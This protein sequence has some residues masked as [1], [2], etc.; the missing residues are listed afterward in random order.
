MITNRCHLT[1]IKKIS[2]TRNFFLTNIIFVENEI[3]KSMNQELKYLIALNMLPKIG[4]ITARKL[5]AYTGSPGAVFKEK[6]AHLEKIPGI[7][8][9]LANQIIKNDTLKKAE[10]EIN[11]IQKY[12]I[13][14]LAYLD[15][16]YPHRLKNCED[17]PLLFY[18]KGNIDFNS[19]KVISIIGTRQATDEG[20]TNCESLIKELKLAGHNP[21]I[22]SGLAYGIDITAHRAALKNGLLTVA[23][24]GHGLQMIYPSVHKKYARD[25]VN[26]G[27]LVTEFNHNANF[28]RKN[29]VKR[30][31]I[32]AGISDATIVVESGEKGGAL[33]TADIANSYNRDVF[34]F[35]GRVND[36]YSVGCN[37]LIKTNR[38]ALI[39]SAKDIEYIL[40]W[41][42]KKT[43]QQTV[44]QRKLFVD[45]SKDEQKVL[46]LIQENEQV[47]IDVLCSLANLPMSK[48]SSIL[49]NLEFSGAIVS[50]PGKMYS[51]HP[52]ANKNQT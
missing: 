22:V 9:Y 2:L 46:Q 41:E 17:A 1:I 10:E 52:L 19:Q 27:A 21:V 48:V 42:R 40:G 38:A 47:N 13:N 32:I 36:K 50:L 33:I 12:E 39:E 28:D 6:K 23:V 14:A 43:E 51:I 24:L 49:L 3:A 44:N 4:S 11:F 5:I 30:N 31:R 7:G 25:I 35:P 20:K 45:F 37:R 26:F 16:K 34:A 29:F 15:E 18:Y 8:R